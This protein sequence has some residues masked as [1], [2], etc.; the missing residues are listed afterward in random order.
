[1]C[2]NNASVQP[3][4]NPM[5][6]S[7]STQQQQAAV[8]LKSFSTVATSTTASRSRDVQP[9]IQWLTTVIR[10]PHLSQLQLH[11]IEEAIKGVAEKQNKEG[12]KGG[13]GN[14]FV[15]RL[16]KAFEP[17]GLVIRC[18]GKQSGMWAKEDGW[19]GRMAMLGLEVVGE[20]KRVAVAKW[21]VG[22]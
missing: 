17:T 19:L 12:R 1:M 5:G 10:E 16:N 8:Q 9:Q 21:D 18:L 14:S 4:S 20:R 11:V 2:S 6:S 13:S 3:G 7:R 15:G 22:R